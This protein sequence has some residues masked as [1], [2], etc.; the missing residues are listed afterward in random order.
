LSALR[1]CPEGAR[2]DVAKTG[3]FQYT[4]CSFGRAAFRCNFRTHARQVAIARM[5]KTAGAMQCFDG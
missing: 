2:H 5:S 4:N 1:G 3:C